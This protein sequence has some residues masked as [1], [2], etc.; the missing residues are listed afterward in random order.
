MIEWQVFVT[1]DIP[2]L[3]HTLDATNHEGHSVDSYLSLRCLS[4]NVPEIYL[5][6]QWSLLNDALGNLDK[7]V[8]VP[9][10]LH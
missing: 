4:N 1:T 6:P 8:L 2:S 7:E 9:F 5:L 3:S 10:S